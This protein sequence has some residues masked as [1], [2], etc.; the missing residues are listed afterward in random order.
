MKPK[1]PRLITDSLHK[2]P[3]CLMCD[4]R[5]VARR[6][7]AKGK[8]CSGACAAAWAMKQVAEEWWCPLHGAWTDCWS[9]W[10]GSCLAEI[11]EFYEPGCEN[12]DRMSEWADAQK[13]ED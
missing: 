7:P 11:N 8:F 3:R 10:P 9:G 12:N 4:V 5:A 2:T 1:G 6:G 13:G